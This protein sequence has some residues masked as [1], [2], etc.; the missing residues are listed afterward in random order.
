MKKWLKAAWVH[1]GSWLVSIGIIGALI[2]MG[3]YGFCEEPIALHELLTLVGGIICGVL[4]F[5]LVPVGL[6]LLG[7][8]LYAIGSP[9]SSRF[10][11][12]VPLLLCNLC[13]AG[14]LVLT[15]FSPA[16][17]EVSSLAVL[18]FVLELMVAPIGG[19]FLLRTFLIGRFR[20]KEVTDLS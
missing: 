18:L 14:L 15:R 13:A 3:Y 4:G 7:A 6:L 11:F 20:R 9:S 17:M 10:D 8:T 2:L 12:L 5:L 19:V 16:L 1:V